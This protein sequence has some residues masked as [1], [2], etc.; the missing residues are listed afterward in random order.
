MERAGTPR[1]IGNVGV[2]RTEAE[3]GANPE[4]TVNRAQRFEHRGIGRQLR[5][6]SVT[7]SCDGESEGSAAAATKLFGNL[8]GATDCIFDGAMEGHLK[9]QEL[10]GACRTKI[11]RSHR[12]LGNG[13]HAGAA[14]DGSNVQRGARFVWELGFAH[15][16][17]CRCKS[18]DRVWSAGIG[19]AVAARSADFNLKA[20]AAESLCHGRVSARAIENDMSSHAARQ[21]GIVVKWRMP[22]RSPSPSSPTF[23]ITTRGTGNSTSA[24]IQRMDK[25]QHSGHACSIVGSAGRFEAEASVCLGHL[26]L[27]GVAAGKTVSRCAESTTTGPLLSAGR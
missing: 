16:G 6:G 2:G 9:T 4:M 24:M 10:V 11:N 15:N 3:V 26:G 14:V 25:C 17:E 7:D 12:A 23:A 21:K 8:I 22:R 20:Q 5:S 13:I 19:K 27:S 18:G 1:A